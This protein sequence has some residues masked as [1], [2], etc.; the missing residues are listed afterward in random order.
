M[1]PELW[2]VVPQPQP[3]ATFPLPSVSP[4]VLKNVLENE[5]HIKITRTQ[6]TSIVPMFGFGKNF[7]SAAEN[8]GFSWW[9]R[10]R[11]SLCTP[12]LWIFRANYQLKGGKR[13]A[14]ERQDL[15]LRVV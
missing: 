13:H 15:L 6:F 2:L 3:T 10:H 7:V 14:N 8:Y 1:W 5:L 12:K 11:F 9:K 4:N